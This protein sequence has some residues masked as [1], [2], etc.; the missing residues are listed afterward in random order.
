M[1][2]NIIAFYTYHNFSEEKP[3]LVL[4]TYGHI[5][6]MSAQQSRNA[7]MEGRNFSR[8][9]FSVGFT[10]LAAFIGNY[11]FCATMRSHF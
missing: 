1:N 3:L 7:Y 4:L 5:I 10:K 8:I 6:E 2:G 11:A 9:K